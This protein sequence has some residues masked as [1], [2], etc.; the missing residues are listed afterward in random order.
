MAPTGT[1]S[2]PPRPAS[3]AR[4]HPEF[5]FAPDQL[6]KRAQEWGKDTPD[7]RVADAWHAYADWVDGWLTFEHHEGADAVTATWRASWLTTTDPRVGR[8]RTLV[9]TGGTEPAEQEGAP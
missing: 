3:P 5:F 4:P 1:R 8:R 9:A 7:E 2:P 6:A